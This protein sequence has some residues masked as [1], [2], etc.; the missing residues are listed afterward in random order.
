MNKNSISLNTKWYG[1]ISI[2][3]AI[4][5][6]IGAFSPSASGNIKLVSL[7]ICI[8][9]LA[10]G[11]GILLSQWWGGAIFSG[12]FPFDFSFHWLGMY[13]SILMIVGR[14]L[15]MMDRAFI[16]LGFVLN[17]V[18]IWLPLAVILRCVQPGRDWY[19]LYI[20]ANTISLVAFIIN[21]GPLSAL[22]L[23]PSSSIFVFFV[24]QEGARRAK[25]VG[26]KVLAES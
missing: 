8:G 26:C 18:F 23:M 25:I 19:R 4:I 6:A 5:Y 7:I 2:G 15:S 13:A 22:W 21:Y 24:V 12:L 3:L 1:L 14:Q 11:I 20:I 9:Y 16:L 10:G 17:I